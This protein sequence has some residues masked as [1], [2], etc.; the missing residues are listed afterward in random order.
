MNS[1]ALEDDVK[2]G[3]LNVTQSTPEVTAL[4]NAGPRRVVDNYD[5]D[6]GLD[7]SADFASGQSDATLYGL[8]GSTGVAV[9]VD[10]TGASAGAND[11]NYDSTSMV[12]E[13]YGLKWG[14]GQAVDFSAKLKGNSALARAVA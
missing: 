12:L 4:D 6:L 14:V 1:V 2:S 9:S 5:Y 11:P 3:S 8:V 10:P 13:S 7:G